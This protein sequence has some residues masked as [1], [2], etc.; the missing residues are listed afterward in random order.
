VADA[1]P[2]QAMVD[3]GTAEANDRAISDHLPTSERRRKVFGDGL[4]AKRRT[5][6]PLRRALILDVFAKSRLK[7]DDLKPMAVS[8]QLLVPF[9][10]PAYMSASSILM[11]RSQM[12]FYEGNQGNLSDGIGRYRYIYGTRFSPITNTAEASNGPSSGLLS[13]RVLA[14]FVI[15]SFTAS[16]IALSQLPLQ[17]RV[18]VRHRQLPQRLATN[19]VSEPEV[20]RSM[21][22]AWWMK[23]QKCYPS[24]SEKSLCLN[25][26]QDHQPPLFILATD[27][28]YLWRRFKT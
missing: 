23:G 3:G 12:N 17:P 13:V 11:G 20:E 1:T 28:R 5:P 18:V 8:I 26:L 7:A 24:I 16:S 14:G 10:D 22:D 27:P 19:A 21:I 25:T 4:G 9:T 2:R 15:A 6:I